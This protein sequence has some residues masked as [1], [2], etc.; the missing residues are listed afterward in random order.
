[1]CFFLLTLSDQSYLASGFQETLV[2]DADHQHVG[3][4][5]SGDQV[6]HRLHQ[7]LRNYGAAVICVQLPTSPAFSGV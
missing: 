5:F 6:L 3:I 2:P 4:G 7:A 1:M